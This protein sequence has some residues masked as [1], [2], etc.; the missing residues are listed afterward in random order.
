MR[1]AFRTIS[2]RKVQIGS[3]RRRK[4][5]N[6][7]RATEQISSNSP[8]FY[9]LNAIM[10][11]L[12]ATLWK[13]KLSLAPFY[14]YCH[15]EICSNLGEEWLLHTFGEAGWYMLSHDAKLWAWRKK[16]LSSSLWTV[17]VK[18]SAS[19]RFSMICRS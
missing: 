19:N 13:D 5:A 3:I 7:R 17:S 10:L 18:P 11:F 15:K 12:H 16:K 1:A 4:V 2:C 8:L 6:L 9:R 14:G